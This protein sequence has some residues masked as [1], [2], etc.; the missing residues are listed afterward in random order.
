MNH[1]DPFCSTRA[2]FIQNKQ[3][4]IQKTHGKGENEPK[5]KLTHN[6]NWSMHLVDLNR[7]VEISVLLRLWSSRGGVGGLGQREHSTM[8]TIR[9]LI[10]FAKSV[11]YLNKSKTLEGFWV[12][13]KCIDVYVLIV[14]AYWYYATCF[15]L[16]CKIEF[17]IR[18]KIIR[19]R[20]VAG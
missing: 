7:K 6:K 19:G 1:P 8:I 16:S 11:L 20:F 9:D 3:M 5:K 14:S 18:A 2:I 4:G 12:K 13:I 15:I 17:F 10:F